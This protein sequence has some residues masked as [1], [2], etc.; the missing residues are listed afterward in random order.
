MSPLGIAVKQLISNAFGLFVYG[1]FANLENKRGLTKKHTVGQQKRLRMSA[2]LI[3]HSNVWLLKASRGR[4]GN[5]FLGR[6]LLLLTT[7]GRK[8]GLPRT[9][10]VFYLEDGE[11]LL[12]VASNG[13][14]TEDP[15]WLQ[16]ARVHPDVDV[17]IRGQ[18]QR[19]RLRIA[20]DAEKSQLWP[21]MTE[22]FPYWQEVADRCERNIP[23]VILDPIH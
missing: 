11:R 22:A 17:S 14:H 15:L 12:M 5:S 9:Q 1:E 10:P 18:H 16:N 21:H 13:G 6:P 23:V 19:M 4:L 7:T 3:T 2:R 8:S 20:S